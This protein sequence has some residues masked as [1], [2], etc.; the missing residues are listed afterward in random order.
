MPTEAVESARFSRA[1]FDLEDGPVVF[2]DADDVRRAMK[3]W[4]DLHTVRNFWIARI[5]LERGQL[6]GESV[7]IARDTQPSE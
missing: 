1:R 2:I 7:R 6:N 5:D 3:R 4:L